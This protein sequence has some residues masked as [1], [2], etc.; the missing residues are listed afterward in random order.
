M[1]FI[2][3]TEGDQTL[4]QVP[5]RDCAVCIHEDIQNQTEH[6]PGRPAHLAWVGRGWTS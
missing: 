5:Q 6:G 4:E 1:Q 3:F 2:F